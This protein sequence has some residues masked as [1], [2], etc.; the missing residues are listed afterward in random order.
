MN[1]IGVM[2]RTQRL[3]HATPRYSCRGFNQGER[4]RIRNIR[5]QRV[6]SDEAWNRVEDRSDGKRGKLLTPC[7]HHRCA[8]G[9]TIASFD[10][11]IVAA[12][13]KV[14]PSVVNVSDVKLIQDAYLQVHP[15]QGVG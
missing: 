15:V 6:Q 5:M 8:R 3:P 14:M 2:F 13:E 12:V 7:E 9:D 10:D 4:S 11:T 1:I